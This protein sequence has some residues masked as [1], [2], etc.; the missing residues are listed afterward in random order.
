MV[1]KSKIG[2]SEWDNKDLQSRLRKRVKKQTGVRITNTDIN[3]IWNTFIEEEILPTLMINSIYNFGG[4]V[5]LWVKATPIMEHKRAVALLRKGLM[6]RRRK[7]I[8]AK[9][10]YDSGKYIYKICLDTE[11][12]KGKRIYFKPN[13]KLKKVVRESIN[14]NKLITRFNVN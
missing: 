8:D 6:Y 10:N 12:K 14:K 3:K 5:K 11:N 1:N 7:V 13:E 9:I 4:G 2:L